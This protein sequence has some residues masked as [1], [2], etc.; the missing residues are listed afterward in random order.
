MFGFEETEERDVVNTR[1]DFPGFLVDARKVTLVPA[2]GCRP[3]GIPVGCQHG[4]I[5]RY[6]KVPSWLDAGK[7]MGLTCRIADGGESCDAP[8]TLVTVQV[9]GVCDTQMRPVSGVH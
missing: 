2:T 8:S 9:G 7:P 5:G 3:Y 4:E 1:D 6:R